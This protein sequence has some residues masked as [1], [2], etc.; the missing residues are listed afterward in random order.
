M[1]N[2][3]MITTESLHLRPLSAADFEQHHELNGH[4]EVFRYLG[5]KPTS[6]EASW[7]RCLAQVGHWVSFGYG[8]FTI[9]EKVSGRLIGRAG[10]FRSERGLGPDFDPFPESGWILHPSVWGLGYA[11]EAVL[12]S[13]EWF[14]MAHRTARTVCI[15]SPD[16]AA[17]LKIA[18][19]LGYAETGTVA[20]QGDDVLT[21]T[22]FVAA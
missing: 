10:L 7:N 18:R 12:A 17:S 19:Q 4:P 8:M 1:F 15:I 16:N 2:A 20:Y 14:D 21:L 6:R 13:H 11:R 3:V 9:E 5:G 22:R